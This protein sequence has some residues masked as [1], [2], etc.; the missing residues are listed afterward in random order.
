MRCRR[1]M[2]GPMRH[3]IWAAVVPAAALA[4]SATACYPKAGEVPPPPTPA[5]AQRASA[6]WPDAT[7]ETLALG[8]GVFASKCNACHA[9]PDVKA[10]PEDKWPGIVDRMAKEAKLDDKQKIATLRFILVARETR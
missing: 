9:H 3:R 1:A 10:I 8:R 4:I 7:E 5:D 6:K 2:L